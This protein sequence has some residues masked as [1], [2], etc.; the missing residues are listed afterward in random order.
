MTDTAGGSKRARVRRAAWL[1][2][3]VALALAVLAVAPTM[4]LARNRNAYA[5]A[6]LISD[7]ATW[8]PTVDP[9]LVNG[10]GLAAGPT[11]PWWVADNGT[12]L[13]TVYNGDGTIRPLV[14]SVM[15]APTGIVFNGGTGFKVGSGETSGAARFIFA[16][17]EGTILGWNTAVPAAGSTTAFVMADRSNVGAVYKGLAIATLEGA[18][19]LY[20]TDFKNGR[21][22]VFGPDWG[23]HS[24][25]AGA[26][27]D[28]KL[29][30]DY[31]PFGI[32]AVGDRIFVTFAKQQAG[33]TDE[34]A[35]QGRGFVDEFDVN[36]HLVARVAT[37]GQLNAPWGIAMAPVSGFDKFNGCLLVGNFGDGHINGYK[38]DR[39]GHWKPVGALRTT[40]GKK[41]TIDGLWG[42]AFGHGSGTPSG[43]ADALYFSAGPGDESHG[44]F[45]RIMTR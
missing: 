4:A 36:G 34:L 40:R 9:N 8:A 35:G 23:M 42:I 30:K 15:S 41:V 14:V 43:P 18:L 13:S 22:D 44:L 33:S 26:F 7:V 28:K 3:V 11:T 29:P 12:D 27:T 1:V 32:Q 37:R 21:V 39:H 2:M 16:T 38:K 45:G 6:P 25:G 10:W 20:A 24:L 19:H 31:A 17:E 5:V